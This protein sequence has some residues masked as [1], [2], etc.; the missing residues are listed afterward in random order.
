MI[1]RIQFIV[2]G[3]LLLSY[4]IYAEERSP[5]SVESDVYIVVLKNSVTRNNSTAD[6]AN[7]LI[8]IARSATLASAFSPNRDVHGF[9]SSGVTSMK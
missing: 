3:C 4:S 2:V 8:K 9:F 7:Q 6:I 1:R 5:N